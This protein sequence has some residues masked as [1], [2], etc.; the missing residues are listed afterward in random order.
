[1]PYAVYSAL[2]T[3][4]RFGF[5]PR[6]LNVG[7]NFVFGVI[8]CYG[9]WK[10]LEWGLVKDRA[11]YTWVGFD[12]PEV[13]KEGMTSSQRKEKKRERWVASRAKEAEQHSP[14]EI[15]KWTTHLVTSVRG[16]GWAWG[17]SRHAVAAPLS[18]QPTAFFRQSL[19]TTL[20]TH[21]IVVNC[22]AV[23]LSPQITRVKVLARLLPFVP[24]EHL[25]LLASWT[26]AFSLG[27]A[28]FA[29][30]TLGFELFTLLIFLATQLL[31]TLPIPTALRPPPFDP[32]QYPPLFNQAFESESVA[33]FWSEGWH[34]FF[35]RPFKTLAF[36]PASR[37][38]TPIAGKLA[39]R[40]AGLMSVFAM[41]AWLHEQGTRLTTTS[42]WCK[43]H[44]NARPSAFP[45]TAIWSATHTF[46][47]GNSLPFV[48]RWGGSIY[49]LGQGF[50]IMLE[51]AFTAITGRKVGGRLGSTW[52]W[53]WIGLLGFVLYRSWYVS[54]RCTL[55]IG[56][57]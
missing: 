22:A 23:I 11:P 5:L 56:S 46:F 45:I 12:E 33:R 39:G 2:I 18:S 43:Y 9:S 1:M 48:L 34:A 19:R 42:F 53:L 44:A 49:F 8:A 40:A 31:R 15:L 13:P 29:G 26:A 30:L 27:C 35:S 14:I 52:K 47:K 36:G 10:G 4:F 28:V 20:I 32:R 6:E 50:A 38:V 25:P 21:F 24:S 54:A 51:G 55:L 7:A 17:P 57:C 41:S 3:P 37:I 16:N